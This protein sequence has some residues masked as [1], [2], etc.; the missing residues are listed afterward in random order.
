MASATQFCIHFCNSGFNHDISYF[1]GSD[2]ERARGIDFV[3]FVIEL[4]GSA[5]PILMMCNTL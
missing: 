4:G 5:V 1:T 3:N 2:G